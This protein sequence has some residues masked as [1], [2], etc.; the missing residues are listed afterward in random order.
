MVGELGIMVGE[1]GEDGGRMVK[2]ILTKPP[3]PTLVSR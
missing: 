2:S 3:I 1:L